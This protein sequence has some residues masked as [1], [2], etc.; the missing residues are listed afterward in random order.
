MDTHDLSAHYGAARAKATNCLG[1]SHYAA[2][3]GLKE[4]CAPLRRDSDL[5]GHRWILK[6]PTLG[7]GCDKTTIRASGTSI[8]L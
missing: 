4:R 3:C 1:E 5:F 8:T 6:A 2:P 7:S